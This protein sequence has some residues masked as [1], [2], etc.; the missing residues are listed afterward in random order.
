MVE[1]G[2]LGVLVRTV[3]YDLTGNEEVMLPL[4]ADT[5]ILVDATQRP[6]PTKPVILNEWIGVMPPHAVLLDL[7]VDPYKCETEPFYV[8]GI[9]GIPQGNLDKYVFPPD[10]P[11]YDSVPKYFANSNRR[12]A[13]SC[14]SWPGI[15]PK[16]CMEL[17]GR[18]LRPIMRELIDKGGIEYI[19][20]AGRYFER[21]IA[22]AQLSRWG[23]ANSSFPPGV[24]MVS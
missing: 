3:D 9:E 2:A 22:R 7:S 17:Y 8:K 11:A 18:Q 10:D 19:N 15:Y 1:A 20:P 6:D 4:L 14:Y 24:S 5:D 13:V 23:L 12:Y 16:Q 21:A